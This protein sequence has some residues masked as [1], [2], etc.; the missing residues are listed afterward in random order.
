MKSPSPKLYMTLWD[1]II[2]SDILFWLDISLLRD[3]VTELDIITVFDV[4][5]YFWKVSIEHLQWARLA[6]DAYSW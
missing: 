6:K 3:S 5:I 4:I 2:Y 1:M